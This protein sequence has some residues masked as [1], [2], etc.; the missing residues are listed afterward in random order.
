M[1]DEPPVDNVQRASRMKLFAAYLAFID[2][3]TIGETLLGWDADH[4]VW[5]FRWQ[6]YIAGEWLSCVEILHPE[7]LEFSVFSGEEVGQRWAERWAMSMKMLGHNIA[8][9][10]R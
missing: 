4:Q 9:G 3:V 1:I 5:K 7:E 6:G 10:D 2:E 8:R